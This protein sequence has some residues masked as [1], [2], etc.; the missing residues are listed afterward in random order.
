[1]SSARRVAIAMMFYV[2]C[3]ALHSA[4]LI[5]DDGTN[6]VSIAPTT[7]WKP[8]RAIDRMALDSRGTVLSV[9]GLRTVSCIDV[10]TTAQQAEVEL[11]PLSFN[12]ASVLSAMVF[13]PDGKQLVWA[14]R[15]GRIVWWSTESKTMTR[16]IREPWFFEDD[17][18]SDVDPG[19][20]RLYRPFVP[21]ESLALSGD[22]TFVAAG[23]VDGTVHVW[24]AATGKYLTEIG[25]RSSTRKSVLLADLFPEDNARQ[26]FAARL[27]KT[28]SDNKAGELADV[29]ECQLWRLEGRE[30]N[31]TFVALD[32]GGATLAFEC[33]AT[34]RVC[35][36]PTK[37]EILTVE[38]C[39]A[40]L[41]A[42]R[43][44]VICWQPEQQQITTIDLNEPSRRNVKHFDIAGHS[45]RKLIALPGLRCVLSECEDGIIRQSELATGRLIASF[46]TAPGRDGI[47]EWCVSADG[48]R[49]AV[50]W[51]KQ[52]ISI[53][54][55]PL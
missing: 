35:G 32:K 16:I 50:R 42:D 38:H 30:R 34:L 48:T 40:T 6:P 43:G 13:A 14:G 53:F 10:R 54:Q 4:A 47:G 26:S 45:I 1:M 41:S 22:G 19:A 5:A 17:R 21:F 36:L 27:G 11:D 51:W 33:G 31:V 28:T 55:F 52:G 44:A 8:S 12:D 9:S 7:I 3:T 20:I 49:L 37:E 2:L 24:N 15:D 23:T 46:A 18:K 39:Q 29:A 25:T